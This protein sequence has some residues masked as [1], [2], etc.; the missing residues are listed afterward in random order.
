MAQPESDEEVYDESLKPTADDDVEH[1]K[2]SS[3]V[4]L[5][6]RLDNN[7]RSYEVHSSGPDTE[8]ELERVAQ[9]S[10]L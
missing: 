5:A 3:P 1:D 6:E 10:K 2:A 8:D 4:N 7:N 9:E